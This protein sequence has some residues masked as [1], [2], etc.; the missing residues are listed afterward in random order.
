MGSPS[1]I[2]TTEVQAF[3]IS[4]FC[5]STA[6]RPPLFEQTDL[7]Q[8]TQGCAILQPVG[9]AGVLNLNFMLLVAQT[10]FHGINTLSSEKTLSIPRSMLS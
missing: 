1:I 10:I 6:C 9:L 8:H 5:L 3:G 4:L 2:M 7:I